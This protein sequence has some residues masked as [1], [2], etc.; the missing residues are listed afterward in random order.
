M[1]SGTAFDLQVFT[2]RETAELLGVSIDTFLRLE[3]AGEAPDRTQ[4]SHRRVG[5][6]G[7]AIRAWQ[8]ARLVAPS[9][10][11]LMDEQGGKAA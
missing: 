4:L 11:Q 6:I 7:R 3:L 8:D 9:A 5:Y 2:K 10:R 1:L